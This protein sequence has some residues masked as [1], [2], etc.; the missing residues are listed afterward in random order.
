MRKF[1]TDELKMFKEL[2]GDPVEFSKAF[3]KNPSDGSPFVPSRIQ[4]RYLRSDA[5]AV[6]CCFH[7]RAG[8]CLEGSVR[9]VDP[10]TLRPTPIAELSSIDET[11]VFDFKANDVVWSKAK[12]H[13][14]SER[15]LC[16]KLEL[17]TGVELILS[18]DHEVFT[19]DQGWVKAKD[20]GAGTKLLAPTHLPIEGDTEGTDEDIQ[21]LIGSNETK[22]EDIPDVVFKLTNRALARYFYAL[23]SRFGRVFRESEYIRL[24]TNNKALATDLHH[25]LLRLSVSARIDETGSILITDDIDITRFLNQIGMDIPILDVRAPRRWEVVLGIKSFGYRDVYDIEVDHHDHNFIAND[26]VV[27]NSYGLSSRCI[28]NA[29]TEPNQR[30]LIF[31]P[32]ETQRKEIFTN[33]DGFVRTSPLINA[34]KHKPWSNSNPYLRGFRN[35]SVIEGHILGVGDNSVTRESRRGLTADY[36]FLDEAQDFTDE[37]WRVLL[38]IIRGNLYRPCKQAYIFGTIVKPQGHYFDMIFKPEMKTANDEIMR[39]PIHENPDFAERPEKIEELMRGTP[40]MIW[41]TEYLLLPS[42]LD[43]SVFRMEHVDQAFAKDYSY[44]TD[45]IRQGHIRVMGVDWDK[46]QAGTTIL[47]GQYDPINKDVKMIYR[48]EVPPGQ[49]TLSIAVD[50]IFELYKE[51]AVDIVTADTGFAGMQIE[52]LILKS[53]DLELDLHTKLIP[54]TMQ[55]KVESPDFQNPDNTIRSYMKDFIVELTRRKFE[56][57]LIHFPTSDQKAKDQFYLYEVVRETESRRVYSKED[58]HIIDA[59]AFILYGIFKAMDNFLGA[60]FGETAGVRM[61]NTAPTYREIEHA[62]KDAWSTYDDREYKPY[63]GSY[64]PSEEY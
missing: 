26:V 62:E 41:K 50:R 64:W 35:N 9:V 59:T 20:I 42:S 30:I 15:K 39:I 10:I 5:E 29:V 12:W 6:W 48:E 33:I 63:R 34:L 3:F 18:E 19:R 16:L 1:S 38:P 56:E 2:A 46:V 51:F 27:H 53:I 44:G 54:I 58:E 22:L 24:S 61:I 49:F 21:K 40:E 13:K 55:S 43:T 47:I 14:N 23:W 52:Q 11:Q 32:S 28:Y 36:A 8:K 57:G 45:L 37:T 4:E 17:E 25:L 7:R 60:S 31:C